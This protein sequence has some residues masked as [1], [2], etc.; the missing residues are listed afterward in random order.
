MLITHPL[1]IKALFLIAVLLSTWVIMAP[2]RS[3]IKVTTTN[4]NS[5][6]RFYELEQYYNAFAGKSW[7]IVEVK[8]SKFLP[9]SADVKFNAGIRRIMNELCLSE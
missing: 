5:G 4:W 7:S 8:F 3:M 6:R 2:L 1:K 9:P